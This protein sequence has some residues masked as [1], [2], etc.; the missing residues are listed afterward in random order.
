MCTSPLL[1]TTRPLMVL[2]DASFIDARFDHFG[3][4][5]KLS[6]YTRSELTFVNRYPS[7]VGSESPAE[8]GLAAAE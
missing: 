1:N 4:G 5:Y 2:N 7:N 8:G 6:S 3:A